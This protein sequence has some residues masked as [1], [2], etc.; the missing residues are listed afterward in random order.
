[1]DEW[2]DAHGNTLPPSNPGA[3]Q[4]AMEQAWYG[5]LGKLT[6]PKRQRNFAT[7]KN[8]PTYAEKIG[9]LK[10]TEIRA[11]KQSSGTIIK[12]AGNQ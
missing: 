12:K 9:E 4:Y 10:M 3:F 2:S 6:M 7:K 1:M 8:L 5:P 11:I